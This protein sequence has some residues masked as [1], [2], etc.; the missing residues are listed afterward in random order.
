MATNFQNLSMKQLSEYIQK[1]D[2]GFADLSRCKEAKSVLR[3][4]LLNEQALLQRQLRAIQKE[5][6]CF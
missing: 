2:L 3:C 6:Q 1:G 5:L 4:N